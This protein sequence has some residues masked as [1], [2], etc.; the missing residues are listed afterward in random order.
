ML[1]LFRRKGSS[2]RLCL[3]VVPS[4]VIGTVVD[5]EFIPHPNLASRSDENLSS[6]S[7]VKLHIGNVPLGFERETVL[8]GHMWSGLI[9]EKT[10]NPRIGFECTNFAR[11]VVLIPIARFKPIRQEVII[12]NVPVHTIRVLRRTSARANNL[13]SIKGLQKA[14]SVS[15]RLVSESNKIVVES[16]HGKIVGQNTRINQGKLD[17]GVKGSQRVQTS[18]GIVSD[19]RR[20]HKEVVLE[21]VR[22]FQARLSTTKRCGTKLEEEPSTLICFGEPVSLNGAT[23]LFQ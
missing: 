5:Q 1:E 22:V 21:L 23:H 15:L 9:H 16:T 18:P 20:H 10:G 13:N 4:I 8:K 12:E 7:L 3:L 6:G 14:H 19:G 11:D 17:I 2:S